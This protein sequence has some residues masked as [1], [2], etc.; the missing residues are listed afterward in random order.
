MLYSRT[1]KIPITHLENIATPQQVEYKRSPSYLLLDKLNKQAA[2]AAQSPREHIM[3]RKCGIEGRFARVRKLAALST[4]MGF[5]MC[6]FMRPIQLQ[7]GG[8]NY[9]NH[10]SR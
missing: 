10:P 2:A 3:C 9:S 5:G 7:P 1:V 4:Y 6:Y 8:H